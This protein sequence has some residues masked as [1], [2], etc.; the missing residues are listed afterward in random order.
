MVKFSKAT[1]NELSF[2]LSL[3]LS[4]SHSLYLCVYRGFGV[5]PI[6]FSVSN[7]LLRWYSMCIKGFMST[8]KSKFVVHMM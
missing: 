1:K 5:N 8:N 7:N 2:P 4:L 6:S 3:S